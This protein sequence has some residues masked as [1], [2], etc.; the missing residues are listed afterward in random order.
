MVGVKM[1][2]D[3]L[4]ALDA[5]ISEQRDPKLTR[6]EAARRLMAAGLKV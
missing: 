1:L 2:P 6:P 3:E 5:W 4:A